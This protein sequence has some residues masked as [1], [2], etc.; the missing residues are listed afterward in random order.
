METTTAGI[1]IQ[2]P[3]LDIHTVAAG[4]GSRLFF[5]S[6]LFVVGPE[7]A[8]ASPG[9]I[10]Y[11]KNG[12]LAVTDANLVLG[13]IIPEFFPHIFGKN[14]DQP[15][16]RQ[17]AV[18][19]MQKVTDEANDFYR[20]HAN[21]SRPEMTVAETALGFID[22]ANETMCRAIRSITQSKGHDTSQ[23]VL[24][25]FG[26]AGGQHAC[27]IAKS[28]GIESVFV[29]RYSGVLSAYGLALA[30]V[31]HEAQEPAAKVFSKGEKRKF[32]HKFQCS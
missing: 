29:H 26:G 24:A 4:G 14:E 30:N 17:A 22:V 3:Q 25:C 23:H 31:V 10:S 5:R 28:L 11:R 20:N 9:P 21:V 2:A 1:T 8:G 16:D 18:E 12:F 7:S 27:A 19:A 32:L 15:L 6:G 13:R